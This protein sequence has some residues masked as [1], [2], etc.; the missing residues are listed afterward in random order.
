MFSSA[1]IFRHLRGRPIF[2][3]APPPSASA[4]WNTSCVAAAADQPNDRPGDA[5]EAIRT[6]GGGSV[7]HA[8]SVL[9]PACLPPRDME[10]A[11]T[12]TAAAAVVE[13]C[14]SIPCHRFTGVHKSI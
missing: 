11:L 6:I 10:K 7:Y 14:A 1:I 9:T 2:L 8:Y 13:A 4:A 5:A 3:M 12:T